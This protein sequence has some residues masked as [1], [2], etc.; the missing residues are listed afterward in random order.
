MKGNLHTPNLAL[1]VWSEEWSVLI[2]TFGTLHIFHVCYLS[3]D[4]PFHS[5]TSI[6]FEVHLEP[7]RRAGM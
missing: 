4:A 6:A 5:V 7:A 3:K 1:H 2:T